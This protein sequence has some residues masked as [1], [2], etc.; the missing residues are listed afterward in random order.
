VSGL[1]DLPR[2]LGVAVVGIPVVLGALVLDGWILGGMMAIAAVVGASEF[3]NLRRHAGE[4]PFVPLGAVGAGGAVLLATAYPLVDDFSTFALGLLLGMYAVSF[5]AALPL[6]WPGGSPIGSASTTVSGVLYVGVPLAFVPILRA[7][8]ETRGAGAPEEVLP[9][10]GFVLL[11][12]LVTWANDSAAYFTGNAFGRHRLSPTLSPG[13]TWE[14]AVGG[15]AGAVAAAV[16]CAVWFLDE[17]PI[18]S[19]E[20]WEAAVIG[21][22]IGVVAQVGDI[23]ESALK[24]EADVKDSGWVFP[25]HGGML[26]R[27]DSLIW[28]FPFTWLMLQLLGV[29]P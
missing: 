12:L 17:L 27:V 29:L 3:Y 26:D 18:L 2:R 21:G 6:R 4:T 28:T 10:M 24:R 9:A 20:P 7:L 25:G 5:A 16:T 22:V 15:V 14:G 1:R 19:V 8:P 23:V 11:P 13:K